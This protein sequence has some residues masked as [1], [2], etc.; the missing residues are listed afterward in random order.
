LLEI[1]EAEDWTGLSS[2]FLD[3]LALAEGL[4]NLPIDAVSAARL[5]HRILSQS[6]DLGFYG[7]LSQTCH[8]FHLQKFD[9]V[10]EVAEPIGH[11][12]SYSLLA[13]SLELFPG[14]MLFSEHN[15]RVIAKD[16]LRM[17]ALALTP[18]LSW[19]NRD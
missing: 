4:P 15:D 18:N 8:I 13:T 9:P 7:I 10:G 1:V 2:E 12:L 16:T 19:K 6:R 17:S 11:E 5:L 3:V 14:D